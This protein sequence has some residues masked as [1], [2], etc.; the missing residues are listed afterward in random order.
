MFQ[1]GIDFAIARRKK[2]IEFVS[3][4]IQVVFFLNC[5]PYGDE[6]GSLSSILRD[7]VDQQND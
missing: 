5:I 2:A 1:I 6:Y 3:F 7:G 4:S